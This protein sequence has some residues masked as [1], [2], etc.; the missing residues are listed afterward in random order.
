MRRA[1]CIA[2][3]YKLPIS[4][5]KWNTELSGLRVLR[6]PVLLVIK[7]RLVHKMLTEYIYIRVEFGVVKW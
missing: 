6:S 7:N 5:E 4:V 1:V 3:V 2:A